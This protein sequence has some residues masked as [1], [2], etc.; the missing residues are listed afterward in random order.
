MAETRR[1]HHL[2]IPAYFRTSDSKAMKQCQLQWF[3]SYYHQPELPD[4]TYFLFGDVEHTVI[5]ACITD[6]IDLDTALWMAEIELRQGWKDLGTN[7]WVSTSKRPEDIDVLVEEAVRGITQW[8]NEVHPSSPDQHFSYRGFDWP[9]R[10]EYIVR[11]EAG[12]FGNRY[13]IRSEIDTIFTDGEAFTLVDWK[14]GATAKADP[15][16]LWMYHFELMYDERADWY[17]PGTP[18]NGWFHHILGGKYGGKIQEVGEYPGDEAMIHNVR[19][20]EEQKN[21]GRRELDAAFPPT[22][23]WWCNTCR[24]KD[25]CPVFGGSL[26]M[27]DMLESVTWLEEPYGDE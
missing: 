16:Q 11:V 13:P 20:V 14:S 1:K 3:L 6:G 22:P 5:E 15:I 24:A 25:F 8:W 19:W 27:V 2:E 17:P 7:G 23:D 18:F 10:A 4:A 26:N 12:V 21:L 9:P